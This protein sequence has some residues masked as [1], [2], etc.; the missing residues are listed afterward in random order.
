MTRC[1]RNGDPA[2]PRKHPA[3]CRAGL[4]MNG[5][6]LMAP[7]RLDATVD[8]FSRRWMDKVKVYLNGSP[9]TDVIGYDEAM[10]QVVVR[11]QGIAGQWLTPQILFGAV[12]AVPR[13]VVQW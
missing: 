6:V 3:V 9:Q 1:F 5:R 4:M 13:P 12:R 8:G 2:W 7:S 10:G 11:H